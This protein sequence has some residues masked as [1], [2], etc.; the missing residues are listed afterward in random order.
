MSYVGNI[1]TTAAFPFDQFSGNGTTT[2]FTL[3]Y[4]PAG[5]TS[6]I[7]SISGVVQN[8]N[9]Y[10]VSGTTL[11]FTPA[12]PT[13]TNNIAVLYLGLPVV[14][15]LTPG[16]TA[17][18][19]SSV[20]TATAG[21]TVFTPSGTYQA[22]FINVIRNGAQLAP[23]D[24]TATNGTTV[25]LANA[26]TAGDTVVIE[27]FN[28]T[29][30]SGALPL[31]GGTVTGATTFNAGV[32]L[33][34][35]SG[36][37][38]IGTSSP[39]YSLEV[40]QSGGATIYSISDTSANIGAFRYSNDTG[41][42]IVV[43]RKARGTQASPSAVQTNDVIGQWVSQAYGGTNWR[44]VATIDARISNYTSDTNISSFITFS[45]NNASTTVSERMRIDSG[46]NLLINATT[47]AS[48]EKVNITSDGASQEGLIVVNTNTAAGTHTAIG[49]RRPAATTVGNITTTLS[50]TAYVTSSDYRL[51]E[52][53]QPMTG[54]LAKVAALKP[55]T[56]TW[57][58][59][60]SNG[61]GF[62]AHE[63]AEVVPDAVS[64]EKD[65]TNE[66]GSIKP[67]GIDTS[68]L[69]ATLTAAI[70]EQQ[71]MIETLQAKVAALEAK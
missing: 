52:N 14:A 25:T 56:Y 71:Q 13:G 50:S 32:N 69:V 8:P 33:A 44:N 57:K 62:I 38:G 29:S 55:C 5:S 53:V 39:N 54:A 16:N 65:E 10:S 1:P 9:T 12:P 49:F 51:K 45:T 22:G 63:L 27:V 31:T 18:F 11:T 68:F 24:Y 61:Q 66:D 42:A 6:I 4:A 30:I 46:G 43:T 20:F 2:A 60:G 7:V 64:G 40:N 15:T 67:Q 34:T 28:L 70:Q 48:L 3:S 36:N 47:R 37:V 35:S 26:C 41:Q 23:A 59:D 58:I 17:Y 19:S 21:Q